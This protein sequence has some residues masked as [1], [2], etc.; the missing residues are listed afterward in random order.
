MEINHNNKSLIVEGFF[1]GIDETVGIFVDSFTVE[2]VK[3]ND[4]D[5]TDEIEE[6]EM[7]ELDALALKEYLEEIGENK[8]QAYLNR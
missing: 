4:I 7:E 5:I 1:E 6:D 3:H 8:L 2:V